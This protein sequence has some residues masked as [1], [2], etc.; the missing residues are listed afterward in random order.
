M[1]IS[2]YP[3]V[4]RHE[5]LKTYKLKNIKLLIIAIFSLSNY[6]KKLLLENLSDC[7]VEVK[8]L[9]SLD[10]ILSNKYSITDLRNIRFD[11]FFLKKI[12]FKII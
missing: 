9:P 1:K 5:F 8:F 10:Q 12:T 4:S 6:Q 3:I 7:N 2:K 11:D